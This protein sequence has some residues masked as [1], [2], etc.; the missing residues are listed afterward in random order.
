VERE[1]TAQIFNYLIVK[2]E[3]KEKEDVRKE[4]NKEGKKGRKCRHHG[5]KEKLK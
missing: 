4:R 2:R 1:Y 5:S 3:R